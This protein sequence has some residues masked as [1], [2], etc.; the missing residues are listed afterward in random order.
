MRSVV[1][2]RSLLIGILIVFVIGGIA[3]ASLG[4]VSLK[5]KG[6]QT[7]GTWKPT[8]YG[9]G[10]AAD[11]PDLGKEKHFYGGLMKYEVNPNVAGTGEGEALS[12]ILYGFCIELT[13]NSKKEFKPY[14]VVLPEDGQAPQNFLGGP[15]GQAKADLV[16]ELWALHASDFVNWIQGNSDA[17]AIAF[18]IA[19]KE[20]IYDFDGELNAGNETS[21]DTTS[22]NLVVKN[23]NALADQMLAALD[24]EG[25]QAN[26]RALVNENHQDYLIGFG[27]DVPEPTTL[28]LLGLGSM[29]FVKRK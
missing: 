16:R 13:Q 6:M 25:P 23:G 7:S 3:Q 2:V 11:Y 24:G 26:L 21:F 9:P 19:I 20:I 22:G 1:N 5:Y 29:L 4:T 8:L 17:S 28:A 15:I 18:E 27:P 14:D 10:T 12:G